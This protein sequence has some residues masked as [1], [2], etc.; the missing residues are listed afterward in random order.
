M[1]VIHQFL[2]SFSAINNHFRNYRHTLSASNHRLILTK[3]FADWNKCVGASHEFLR[4][5]YFDSSW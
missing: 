2:S 1:P 4:R 3:R 5:S